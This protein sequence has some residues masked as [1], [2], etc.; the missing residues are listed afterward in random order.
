MGSEGG[1][2]ATRAHW[3]SGLGG[4]SQAATVCPGMG[5]PAGGGKGQR[6][7]KGESG[8]AGS[9]TGSKAHSSERPAH[10]VATVPVQPRARLLA[11]ALSSCGGLGGS[12]PVLG[13]SRGW[14]LH[15]HSPPSPVM[16]RVRCPAPGET[17]YTVVWAFPACSRG[18]WA[19]QVTRSL[20]RVL[21]GDT[22]VHLSGGAWV[23]T[24]DQGGGEPVKWGASI[25]DGGL[26][27]ERV[28]K[29]CKVGRWCPG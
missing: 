9:E 27:E 24:R 13:Q 12:P 2:Q 28:C 10:H 15:P 17:G 23:G 16:G 11:C 26:R 18:P 8:Q 1:S 25:Q 6:G 3:N 29:L 22:A 4:R 21:L 19:S 5:G 20:D 14:C 7:S